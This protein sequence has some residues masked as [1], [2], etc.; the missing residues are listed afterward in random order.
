M[1][2]PI[3]TGKFCPGLIN[4]QA[5]INRKAVWSK[6]GEKNH[7]LIILLGVLQSSYRLFGCI[8]VIAREVSYE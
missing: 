5:L 7:R 1:L 3:F 2:D 6:I 8:S 4:R